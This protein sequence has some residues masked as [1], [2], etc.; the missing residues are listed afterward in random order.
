MWVNGP[1]LKLCVRTML[2]RSGTSKKERVSCWVW[3]FPSDVWNCQFEYA[4]LE[5]ASNA[6]FAF[7]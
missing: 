5:V 3:M 6:D 1:V 2:K 4:T 7:M